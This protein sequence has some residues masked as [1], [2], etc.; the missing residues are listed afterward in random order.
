MSLEVGNSDVKS[1]Q[2]I[3]QNIIC[4]I[5]KVPTVDIFKGQSCLECVV[6]SLACSRQ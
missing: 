1:D 2:E 6:A 5:N 3:S 4:S